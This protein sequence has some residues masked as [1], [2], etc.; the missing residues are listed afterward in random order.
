MSI[1][2]LIF[3]TVAVAISAFVY[4]VV[5]T[6]RGHVLDSVNDWLEFRLPEWFYKPL[7]GCQ[8][9]VAG[10][11]ALWF[12][13]YLWFFEGLEYKF[14]LHIWF[15]MQTIFNV[16]IITEFYFQILSKN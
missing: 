1:F 8:F 12:F 2:F 4:S 5:L 13:L 14:Y 7:I 11:W 6:E 9:C 10:Q 16:K 15:V 3:L